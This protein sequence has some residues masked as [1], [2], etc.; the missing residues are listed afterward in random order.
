MEEALKLN[1]SASNTHNSRGSLLLRK[2]RLDESLN[3][4][5]QAIQLQP[6]NTNA[7]YNMA[8][9]YKQKGDIQ[10]AVSAL[11]RL[12]SVDPSHTL[13]RNALAELRH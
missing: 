2:G 1:S 8:L 3:E 7:N 4:F 13:A 9:A 5:H 12:L 6:T 11:E 10:S